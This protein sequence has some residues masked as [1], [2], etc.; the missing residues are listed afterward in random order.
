MVDGG[1]VW[2]DVVIVPYEG[3]W[4]SVHEKRRLL[5]SLLF[6][7]LTYSMTTRRLGSEP[8]E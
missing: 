4:G 8:T 1:A 3:I 2:D 6:D 5:S 7:Y